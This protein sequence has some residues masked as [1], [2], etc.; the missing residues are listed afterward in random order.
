MGKLRFFYGCMGSMKSATL[1]IKAYQF[2]E[3]GADVILLK[4]NFDDRWG[5]GEIKSRAVSKAEECI[6]F[7]Q[8]T[9][10]HELLCV[11]NHIILVDEVQ[12]AT[13]SHIEQLLKLSFDNEVYCYGIKN[14]YNNRLFPASAELLV[15]AST[16]EEIKC[17]CSR[18]N[19][20]ATTHLRLVNGQAM[21]GENDNIVGDI[22]GSER[23]ESVCQKCWHEE[24]EKTLDIVPKIW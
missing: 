10:L 1:L 3:A 7:A 17:K 24:F 2:R 22:V 15:L 13:S 18:C 4:P 14:S 19:S 12:F 9:N 11:K 5:V 8:D 21:F 16:I 6:V 20:K 23:Y